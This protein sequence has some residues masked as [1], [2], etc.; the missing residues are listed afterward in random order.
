MGQLVEIVA[1]GIGAP[2]EVT[3][4]DPEP[5]QTKLVT[6]DGTFVFPFRA[7]DGTHAVTI[8]APEC[9]LSAPSVTV[10]GAKASVSL[11]CDRVVE[12]STVTLDLPF[13]P[14]IAYAPGFDPQRLAYAGQRS[15]LIE[16][17]DTIDVTAGAAY[18][19][20]A[21]TIN[22]IAASSGATASV[23][24]GTGVDVVLSH[25]SGLSRT[26]S[27]GLA[28]QFAMTQEATRKAAAPV[29]L[30]KFSRVA[31]SNDTMVVGAPGDN[32]AGGSAYVFQRSE[33]SWAE[34]LRLAGAA[35]VVGD[36]FGMAVA[37]DGDTLVVGAPGQGGPG[38]AH[39]FVRNGPTWQLQQVLTSAPA[40]NGDR[41][42]AAVAISGNTIVVGAPDEDGTAGNS[43]AAFVFTRGGT[44]WSQ[45]ATLKAQSPGAADA[46]GI[47]VSIWGDSLVAGAPLE[48]GGGK[49]DSGAAFVFVRAGTVW[50]QQGYL[51]ASNAEASDLFGTS[52]GISINTVVAG[53]PGEDSTGSPT[54]NSLLNSGAAY[55]FD[56]SGAVWSA[57]AYL[58]A[59]NIDSSTEFGT[60]VA[61]DRVHLIIGAPK[62]NSAAVGLDGS[63]PLNAFF[64]GAA[65]LYRRTATWTQLRYVKPSNTA[66]FSS[67]GASVTVEGDTFAV[68]APKGASTVDKH[69]EIYIYR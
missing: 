40:V 17:I 50:S 42:G 45:Q 6:E 41:F 31:I 47:S 1:L 66:Q 26:Y 63:S 46:F 7:G 43:G 65:Y 36:G 37:I 48:D 49:T 27:F 2:V 32:P 3:L 13:S 67:F 19:G 23:A 69:G 44:V 62:E 56:R 35:P 38:A 9:R 8:G 5:G 14:Q 28:G 57:G 12:L 4:A 25:P 20:S 51:K 58:K 16:P 22:G 24:L 18:P 64:S 33:R 54:N 34:V 11:T 59:S 15:F 55:T 10:A 60:A 30:D 39:V 61:I 29:A 52:V 68:G 53:A 21:M